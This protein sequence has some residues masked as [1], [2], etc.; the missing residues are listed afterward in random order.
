MHDEPGTVGSTSPEAQA[1]RALCRRLENIGNELL[2][3]PF[4]LDED[5]RAE[6]FDHL[7]RQVLC[8]LGWAV[9]YGEPGSPAFMRQND[10]VLQ[11]GGPNV[12]NVYRHARIDPKRRY[13][14]SGK[15]HGCEEFVLALRA[16]FMHQPKWGTLAEITASSR[17]ITRGGDINLLLGPGEVGEGYIPIP[18]GVV[19]ASLREYYVDWAAREPATLVIECLDPTDVERPGPADLA[20]RF[21]EAVSGVEHSMRYWNRYLT[22]H[23]AAGIDNEFCEAI[24]VSKGLD[25]ARYSFCFWDLAPD[26]ALVVHSS[27]PD[28]P[29]WSMQT[30]R[31]HWF[32]AGDF[33]NHV[34]SLNHRQATQSSEGLVHAVLAHSDPTTPNWIDTEGRRN[35]MLSFRWF[36]GVDNPRISTEVVPLSE[37]RNHLPPDTAQV[38]AETRRR[39]VAD[40]RTH[41][42][43]RYRS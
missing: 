24:K 20:A 42:A 10:L 4:P 17:G 16:G 6:G 28:A 27:V 19:M 30:Y 29:Y 33:A 2:E 25:A 7:A 38:S 40:R 18:E 1:W 13:R 21:D 41:S 11:W 9:G 22:D 12:D 43:W 5:T 32:R 35:G 23:R 39:E 14:I 34:T 15:M 31:L 36:W 3:P 37:V 8:W 26:E